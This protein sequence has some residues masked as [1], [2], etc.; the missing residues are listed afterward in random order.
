MRLQQ[1]EYYK[2]L[3]QNNSYFLD[4]EKFLSTYNSHTYLKTY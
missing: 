3:S 4:N 1:E 2:I